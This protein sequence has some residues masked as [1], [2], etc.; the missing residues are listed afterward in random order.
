MYSSGIYKKLDAVG[1]KKR[2]ELV[3]LLATN[4]LATIHTGVLWAAM[5]MKN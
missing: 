2:C 4:Q 3:G 1:K 5:V